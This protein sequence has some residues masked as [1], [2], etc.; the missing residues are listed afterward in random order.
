MRGAAT[1]AY[2]PGVANWTHGNDTDV[3]VVL[4]HCVTMITVFYNGVTVV[5]P[6]SQSC[7]TLPGVTP[8]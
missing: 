8:A 2:L 6:L 1:D 3:K 4:S 5:L 7:F